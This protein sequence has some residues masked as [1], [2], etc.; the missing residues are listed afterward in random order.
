MQRKVV[1]SCFNNVFGV[2][3][4]TY[5]SVH[6]IELVFIYICGRLAS[7]VYVKQC[8]VKHLY[9]TQSKCYIHMYIFY[10]IALP[11]HKIGFV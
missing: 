9:S 10:I 1:T 2:L 8:N 11:Y 4:D 6:Q 3:T 7:R 5:I